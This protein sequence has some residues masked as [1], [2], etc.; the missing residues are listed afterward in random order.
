MTKRRRFSAKVYASII[1]RQGGVCARSGVP[2]TEGNL[3]FDHVIPLG[4]DESGDVPEN[5][6]ALATPAH[7]QKTRADIARIAKAKRCEKKLTR[8]AIR[9]PKHN[10]PSPRIQSRG[11]PKIHRPFPKRVQM[12]AAQPERN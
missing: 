12:G 1:E 11:F 2:L 9:K 10:W 7:K 4:L 3:Q 5:L 8:D 6:E